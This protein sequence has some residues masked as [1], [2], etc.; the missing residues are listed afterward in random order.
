[1]TGSAH[2]MLTP[3]WIKR[4]KKKE[5]QAL[6]LSKRMGNLKCSIEKDRVKMVGKAKTYLIGE[7]IIPD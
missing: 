4:F 3:Y 5:L 1:M 7:I 2:T 6:Q